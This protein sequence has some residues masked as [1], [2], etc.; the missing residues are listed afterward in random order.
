MKL[1][2]EPGAL[3]AGFSRN[4]VVPPYMM[5]IF[6]PRETHLNH[7][8]ELKR[9]LQMDACLS[10]TKTLLKTNIR[11]IPACNGWVKINT[12]GASKGNPGDA[13]CGGLIRDEEGRWLVGFTKHIDICNCIHS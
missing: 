13:G 6:N 3:P 12:D 1:G 2:L 7:I 5:L 4:G 11:R 10:S 8:S 9:A